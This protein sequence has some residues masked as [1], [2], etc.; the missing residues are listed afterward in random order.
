MVAGSA[1]SSLFKFAVNLVRTFYLKRIAVCVRRLHALLKEGQL[2]TL[3]VLT[4]NFLPIS[5]CFVSS[6]IDCDENRRHWQR[7][8]CGVF[9]SI[10]CLMQAVAYSLRQQISVR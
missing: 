6:R 3:G 5:R 1:F 8:E 2:M 4:W 7:N 9:F 10:M